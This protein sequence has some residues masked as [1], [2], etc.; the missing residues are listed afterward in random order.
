MASF[1][2]RALKP[3]YFHAT[4]LES[5]RRV[6]VGQEELELRLQG[7]APVD[8]L[9]PALG[10]GPVVGV[11]PRDSVHDIRWHQVDVVY[12]WQM[13]VPMV[14]YQ[15]QRRLYARPCDPGQHH[16][17]HAVRRLD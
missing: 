10:P 17:Y 11:E 4:S 7:R 14:V 6:R 1:V 13:I 8:P 3:I 15:E 5:E 2:P 12:V 9:R 16:P